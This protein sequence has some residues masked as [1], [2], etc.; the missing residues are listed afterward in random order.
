MTMTTAH[1][2]PYVDV[3]REQQN[4]DYLRATRFSLRVENKP[5]T[6]V[7]QPGDGTRYKF[8]LVPSPEQVIVS[9]NGRSIA[10]STT[11][12]MLFV[13][14]LDG[15]GRGTA[16]VGR[17]YGINALE[18][19]LREAISFRNDNPC[20]VAAL[21]HTIEALWLD[22]YVVAGDEPDDLQLR[23][24]VYT[25]QGDSKIMR[26]PDGS[27]RCTGYTAESGSDPDEYVA[28]LRRLYNEWKAS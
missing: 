25:D 1:R 17:S 19:A 13:Q 14:V 7:L 11:G 20:T 9:N 23:R 24:M 18:H 28:A 21:L 4:L 3:W 26:M 8:L 12:S 27:E 2:T 16:E 6:V 22:Q 15:L 10:R 5:A